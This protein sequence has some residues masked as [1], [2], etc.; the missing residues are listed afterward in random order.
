MLIMTAANS[1]VGRRSTPARYLFLGEVDAYPASAD[2]EGDPVTP[3]DAKMSTELLDR[4]THHC[5]IIGP[6]TN[7]GAS[8]TAPDH[9]IK[10]P[11]AIRVRPGCAT[12]TKSAQAKADRPAL[13]KEGA[14]LDAD[15]G[16]VLEAV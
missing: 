2:E 13:H 5:E 10:L 4:L 1:A 12:L 3:V 7:P 8:R 14:K 11:S 6:E 16:S 9:P 15:R